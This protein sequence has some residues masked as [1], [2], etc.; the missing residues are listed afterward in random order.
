MMVYDKYGMPAIVLRF[1][2]HKAVPEEPTYEC[3]P[4][5]LLSKEEV[6]ILN[7]M[8]IVSS[9]YGEYIWEALSNEVL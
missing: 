1:W 9:P 4:I 3:K 2:Y 8:S 6:L 5:E 7:E